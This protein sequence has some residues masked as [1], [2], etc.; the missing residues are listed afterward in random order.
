MP[1]YNPPAPTGTGGR[2]TGYHGFA[3]T[4]TPG[5]TGATPAAGAA[6]APT[7]PAQFPNS[8]PVMENP[9][10]AEYGFLDPNAWQNW[11]SFGGSNPNDWQNLS[12]TL[13]TGFLGMGNWTQGNVDPTSVAPTDAASMQASMQPYVDQ[14]YQQA[15]RALD[16][17]Y[18]QAQKQF[19]QQMVNQGIA[20]GSAAYNTAKA[21]FD[22]GKNDAYAQ[23]RAQAE[24]QGA[25]LQSQAFGQGLSQSQL[26]NSL[27]GQLIGANTN[28]LGQQLGG[29]QSL[30]QALLS[31]NNSLFNQLIGGNTSIVGNQLGA[32]ASMANAR[33]AAGASRYG[34]DLQHDIQ[35]Q[36]IDNGMLMNLLGLGQGVTE[37]N[38]GL[39]GYDQ[40]RN[41]Q[42]L[43]Y[44]PNGGAGNIDVQNP[45][46]NFYNGQM[47]NYGYNVNQSN[48]QNQ[49]YLAMLASLFG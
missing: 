47:T 18:E 29:N 24:Q 21:Q 1:Y 8:N 44:L 42:M 45:Y 48:Q 17:Q 6:P 33:S 39:L 16:P 32:N 26:A 15:T 49:A 14:A 10:L 43:N 5:A 35:Q 25:A 2:S 46:N 7:Q 11:A 34:A 41:T 30:A 4:P 3:P 13:G 20:P 37:Y 40:N 31:G 28:I 9:S 19:D 27:T 12:Q 38:N 22:Q 23:A 36:N